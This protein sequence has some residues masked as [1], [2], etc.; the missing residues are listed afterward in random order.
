[1]IAIFANVSELL[2]FSFRV[3]VCGLSTLCSSFFAQFELLSKKVFA[4]F[5]VGG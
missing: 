2:H 5:F 4:R 3:F 1:M